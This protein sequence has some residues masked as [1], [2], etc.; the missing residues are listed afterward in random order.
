[1]TSKAIR[2]S[3][4]LVVLFG[5]VAI[6]GSAQQPVRLS[7]DEAVQ[8]AL[9]HTPRLSAAREVVAQAAGG[10][11]EAQAL[12]WPRLALDGSLFRFEEPMIVAPLHGF[13]PTRVP[14]FDATLVQSSLGLG[15][16]LFDGGQRGGRIGEASALE[17]AAGSQL[18]S[19]EQAVVAAVVQGYAEVLSTVEGLRAQETR[20][21][22]LVAEGDR[23]RRF[24]AEGRAARVEELRVEA[25]VARAR[26]DSSAAAARLDVAE[27][28]LARLL[29]VSRERTAAASL[30]PL[31]VTAA[32]LPDR[33]EIDRDAAA[34]NPAIQAAQS[35]LVAAEAAVRAARAEWFPTVRLEGRAIT[36]GASEGS[37]TTEWQAGVR[38]AYPLFTGGAR[39]GG[40]QRARA[41]A[42]E[43][44][45][46]LRDLEEVLS[47]ELD[48][49]V[50]RVIDARRQVEALGSAVSHLGE[51]V[52]TEALAL[53]EGAGV[54]SDYLRSEAERAGARA[55]LARAASEEIVTRVEL[56]RLMG[57]L[58]RTVVATI[59]ES[60]P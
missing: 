57:R 35:W 11:R 47:G 33:A 37:Y 25:A 51:V 45:A 12:R 34:A 3:T 36:Y 49:A 9:D 19:V 31:K 44:Q 13:D 59:V 55:A 41:A 6:P 29:G 4:H 14:R 26:A 18:R 39:G 20:L 21:L 15:Y 32:S 8:F 7:L 1:M 22:A 17:E 40:I 46:N 16:T 58:D 23:V 54:Q 43:A 52:R 60:A 24:L 50:A 48:R 10:R 30:V 28:A 42:R 5:A 53:S 27:A 2:Q 56:A 38:L